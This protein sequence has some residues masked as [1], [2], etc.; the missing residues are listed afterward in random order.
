M[1]GVARGKINGFG[2]EVIPGYLFHGITAV[3]AIWLFC[4]GI[5]H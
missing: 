4:R 2:F 5:V 1:S 3:L